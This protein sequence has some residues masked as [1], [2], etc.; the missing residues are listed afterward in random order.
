[1]LND[2]LPFGSDAVCKGRCRVRQVNRGPPI[3]LV[4]WATMQL[5]P[6]IFGPKVD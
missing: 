3:N 1:M 2:F 5:A 6:P 4:R